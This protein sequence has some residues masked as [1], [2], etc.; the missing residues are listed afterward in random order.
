MTRLSAY[1][2]HSSSSWLRDY[3]I[4]HHV[5]A[6]VEYLGMADFVDPVVDPGSVI[7]INLS[8]VDGMPVSSSTSFHRCV[9]GGEATFSIDNSD[10]DPHLR[11]MTTPKVDKACWGAIMEIG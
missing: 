10:R 3:H 9:Q 7:S 8:I 11:Y 1:S 4:E 6:V 2:R 5:P